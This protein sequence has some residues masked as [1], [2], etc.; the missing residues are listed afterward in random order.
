MNQDKIDKIFIN[1]L[2]FANLLFRPSLNSKLI[3]NTTIESINNDDIG[4][5]INIPIFW[6]G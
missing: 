5:I 6:V 4:L 1:N 3:K 2:H